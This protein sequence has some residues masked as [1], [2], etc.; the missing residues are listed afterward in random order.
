MV[1]TPR[2]FPLPSAV[3]DSRFTSGVELA[4]GI[5]LRVPR[6]SHILSEKPAVGWFEIISE[7]Y[8]VEGG[9]PLAVL[10]QILDQ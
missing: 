1:R 6:Y 8:T 5:G 9:R 4:T 3:S 7:N 2:G 10:D